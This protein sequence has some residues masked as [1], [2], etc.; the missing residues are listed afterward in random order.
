MHT[1]VRGHRGQYVFLMAKYCNLYGRFL[2]KLDF[3][4]D[5]A[6]YFLGII[7]LISKIGTLTQIR[8]GEGRVTFSIKGP[9]RGQYASLI[10]KCSN[11][12]GRILFHYHFYRPN[13][14]LPID[15]YA[16]K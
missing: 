8:M 7:M 16:Y 11:F 15:N 6:S 13:P 3:S 12:N 9:M 1:Q 2:F 10:A 14:L 4:G 5:S